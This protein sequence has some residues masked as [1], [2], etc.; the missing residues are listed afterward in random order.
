MV[1]FGMPQVNLKLGVGAT[2]SFPFQ[3][4]P[5]KHQSQVKYGINGN[6]TRRLSNLLVAGSRTKQIKSRS[7]FC[8]QLKHSSFKTQEF[9]NIIFYAAA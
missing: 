7:I 3:V 5:P 8:A 9:K 4:I 1:H 6:S 2:V